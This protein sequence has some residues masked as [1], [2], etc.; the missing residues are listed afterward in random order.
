MK[1]RIRGFTLIELLVVIA[2]I[3][4]LANLLL[5]AL[6]KA[7]ARANNIVCLNN[8][9]QITLP[10]KMAFEN[11]SDRFSVNFKPFSSELLDS[12]QFLQSTHNLWAQEEW[13]K[14]N[15]GWICPVAREKPPGGRKKPPSPPF[16]DFEG[17]SGSVNTA[18]ASTSLYSYG[19]LRAPIK[20][21]EHRAGSYSQNSWLSGAWWWAGPQHPDLPAGFL[22]EGQI[23]DPARTPVFGDAVQ[24]DGSGAGFAGWYG[25]LANDLPP[26][27]LEFGWLNGMD[28][29][30]IPRHGSRPSTV[31][32]NH[33]PSRRL[34]GA[35]NMSFWDGHVEQ[36]KLD[37]LW[38]LT[39]HR[40]Y[41]PPL[42]RPGL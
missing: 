37:R 13:G 31:P 17:Y 5:P 8:L 2:I 15:K 33:P 41:Q 26:A 22:T 40:N 7:K 32:T 28:M 30:V 6:S 36:V 14:T 25:P 24:I 19:R 27:N 42:K 34:P 12:D 35:I 21:S 11:D 29:F 3:A 1:T 18:W 10:W 39:W 9:R 23:Q 20:P 16:W 4:I 38:N